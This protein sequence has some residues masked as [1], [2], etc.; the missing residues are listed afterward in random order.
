MNLPLDYKVVLYA[1]T[2]RKNIDFS[3]IAQMKELDIPELIESL[4]KVIGGE[5]W[6]FV[7]RAHN[8]V[9]QKIDFTSI[10]KSNS[11]VLLI[12]GNLHDDMAEYLKCA[13]VLITDY[14]ASMFDFALT[15]KPCFL[16]VPD[17]DEYGSNERGFY[18]QIEAL[19]FPIAR[20]SKEL[21]SAVELYNDVEYKIKIDHLLVEMGNVEDGNA[22]KRVVKDILSFI[23]A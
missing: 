14:S 19:P 12:N 11:N 8:L 6:C 1:P 4:S 20:N 16:Y 9:M 22:S 21:I 7:F 18:T 17:V 10:S 3:G 15:R 23:D 2:F 13:D 5:R